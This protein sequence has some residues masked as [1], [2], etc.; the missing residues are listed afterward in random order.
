MKNQ[1]PLS[2]GINNRYKVHDMQLAGTS[3]IGLAGLGL[4]SFTLYFLVSWGAPLLIYARRPLNPP[5]RCQTRRK[6][7]RP[8]TDC[9]HVY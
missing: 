6:C 2:P 8:L 3:A 9:V 7:A 4:F 1:N 5:E